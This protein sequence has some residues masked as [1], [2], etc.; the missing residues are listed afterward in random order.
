MHNLFRLG[1]EADRSVSRRL[2]WDLQV[3][4][5]PVCLVRLADVAEVTPP[6]DGHEGVEQ[7]PV[8]RGHVRVQDHVVDRPDLLFLFFVPAFVF[9]V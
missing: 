9:S 2:D 6:R 3:L 4:L 5:G 8:G 1:L 7:G